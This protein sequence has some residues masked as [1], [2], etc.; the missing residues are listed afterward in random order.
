MVSRIA[1]RSEERGDEYENTHSEEEPDKTW[2]ELSTFRIHTPDA[3][4]IVPALRT[5]HWVFHHYAPFDL[6]IRKYKG[7][8]VPTSEKCRHNNSK[9]TQA[10]LQ[11]RDN[12]VSKNTRVKGMPRVGRA[13]TWTRWSLHPYGW[14]P[15]MLSRSDASRCLARQ[16]LRCGSGWQVKGRVTVEGPISKSDLFLE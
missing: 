6:Q 14:H 9:L 7:C 8:I 4:C 1:V 5:P 11:A 12:A 13:C 10:L 15:V 2:T 16:T 3:H